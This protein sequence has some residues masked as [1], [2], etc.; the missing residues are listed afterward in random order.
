VAAGSRAIGQVRSRRAGDHRSPPIDSGS[1]LALASGACRQQALAPGWPCC[2]TLADVGLPDHLQTHRL[3]LGRCCCRVFSAAPRGAWH[4]RFRRQAITRCRQPGRSLWLSGRR[5]RH[6]CLGDK[7]IV[8]DGADLCCGGRFLSPRRSRPGN[9]RRTIAFDG[10]QSSRA[11]PAGD[12]FP[13]PAA[14]PGRAIGWRRS[15]RPDPAR[16]ALR[17]TIGFAQTR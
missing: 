11:D 9:R 10:K 8:R 3:D 12:R 2:S 17:R 6:D 15:A 14:S 1:V 16:S 4:D 7:G 5:S 13:R